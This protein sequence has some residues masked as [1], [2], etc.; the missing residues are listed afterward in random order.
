M[1]NRASFALSGLPAETHKFL[2][3]HHKDSIVMVS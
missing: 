1:Q 3:G 2:A